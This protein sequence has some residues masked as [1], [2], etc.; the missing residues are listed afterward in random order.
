MKKLL[1]K[2]I[3][4][5][6]ELKEKTKVNSNNNIDLS[7][8]KNIKYLSSSPSFY[9]EKGINS[10]YYKK[11]YD[12]NQKCRNKSDYFI[13]KNKPKSC[14]E[15]LEKNK[16]IQD[17]YYNPMSEG[18]FDNYF[19]NNYSIKNINNT[20]VYNNIDKESNEKHNIIEI[21]KK[22]NKVDNYKNL[23]NISEKENNQIKKFRENKIIDFSY[24]GGEKN[25]RKQINQNNSIINTVNISFA[26]IRLN[27][28]KEIFDKI[29]ENKNNFENNKDEKDDINKNNNIQNNEY[30]FIK[31]N[32]NDNN[33][34]QYNKSL[35]NNN[36]IK[37]SDIIKTKEEIKEDIK[38]LPLIDPEELE[39]KAVILNKEND[40]KTH[41]DKSLDEKKTSNLKKITFDNI[42]T[43]IKYYENDYIKKSFI[44]S[45]ND[46]KKQK[47]IF[48]PTKD[49][50]QN[51]KKENKIKS[52]LL[53]KEDKNKIKNDKLNLALSKLNQLISEV[54]SES[55][56]KNNK[57]DIKLDN[58][59]NK[60]QFIKKNINFIKKIQ[61]YY[62]KGVNYRCLSK[63]EIKLLKKKNNN[64]CYKFQNNPQNFFSEKLCD[65]IIKTFNFN[66]DDSDLLKNNKKQMIRKK[67]DNYKNEFEGENKLNNSFTE[68]KI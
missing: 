48:L 52:I 30:N 19:I 66:I 39:E 28:N 43:I 49:Y 22:K 35:N 56:K 7:N 36:E 25:N 20:T 60:S 51:L 5:M 68:G 64:M 26:P 11:I 41:D 23:S 10:N 6:I 21:E 58:N 3:D 9:E 54:N 8:K 37:N 1:K 47:H 33:Q 40:S 14:N 32:S 63:R 29:I 24:M 15:K 2:K 50:I 61:E 65:N 17:N 31:N 27:Y 4:K 13:N 53:V 34:I 44:F 46:F 12:K 18:F 55:Q 62:K 67:L 38:K 16:I 59:I 57:E 42:K 45:D